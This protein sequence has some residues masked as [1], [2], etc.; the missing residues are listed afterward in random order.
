MQQVFRHFQAD[1]PA[2][3]HHGFLHIVFL[4]VF[5]DGHRV[6]RRAHLEHPGQLRAFHRGHYRGRAHR[7]YQSVIPIGFRLPCGKVF[8]LHPL[9]LRQDFHSLPQGF[10]L[11]PGEGGKPLGGV[12]NQLPFVL[13]GPAHIVGKAAPGIGDVPAFRQK[14]N[15]CLPV[16][17]LKL[18]GGFCPGGNPAD[19]QQFHISR[20]FPAVLKRRICRE[21]LWQAHLKTG[22]ARF[23]PLLNRFALGNTA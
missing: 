2:A 21:V 16:F 5:P 3:C 18:G 6:P 7:N 15:L 8:G 22:K 14:G 1:K 20:S 12:D 4:Q 11:H 19:N 23:P 10:H 17:P 13:D 9:F